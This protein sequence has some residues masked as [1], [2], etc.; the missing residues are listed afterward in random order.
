MTSLL[1]ILLFSVLTSPPFLALLTNTS[2]SNP[3]FQRL[4]IGSLGIL[5][6]TC[7]CLVL[8]R[9]GLFLFVCLSCQYGKLRG[10][11]LKMWQYGPSPLLNPSCLPGRLKVLS[12]LDKSPLLPCPT[13]FPWFLKVMPLPAIFMPLDPSFLVSVDYNSIHLLNHGVSKF[14]SL[15]VF[16]SPYVPPARWSLHCL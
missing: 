15:A 4:Q 5:P 3:S 14:P 10:F 1:P 9:V 12:L 2:I 6:Q 13:L 11:S 16:H 7:F 8:R